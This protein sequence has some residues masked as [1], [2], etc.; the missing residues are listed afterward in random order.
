MSIQGIKDWTCII[1]TNGEGV[2]GVLK[3]TKKN[4]HVLHVRLFFQVQHVRYTYHG[5]WFLMWRYPIFD[6]TNA[7]SRSAT[8]LGMCGD[9]KYDWSS[10]IMGGDGRPEWASEPLAQ[11]D[12]QGCTSMRVR[13]MS[14]RS[15]PFTRG[16]SACESWTDFLRCAHRDFRTPCP[17]SNMTDWG[18]PDR[19]SSIARAF[20]SFDA[21]REVKEIEELEHDQL[22]FQVFSRIKP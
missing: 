18:S 8:T 14:S 9:E 3:H 4:N 7:S 13:D 16:S 21:A 20:F 6:G 19:L 17:W 12:L 1:R 2:I 22:H 15:C 11:C 10:P 5:T